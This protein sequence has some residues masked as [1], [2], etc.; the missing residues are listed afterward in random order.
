[1][2]PCRSIVVCL[3][4][5]GGCSL[6]AVKATERVLA[7]GGTAAYRIVISKDADVSTKAVGEDFAGILAEIT[8]A[9]FPIVTDDTEPAEQ[10][11]IVGA[12]NT[13]LAKL[14][15]A[16]M[17]KGFSQG[18]YEI[19]TAGGKLVI[20]GGPLRGTINGMYGFLQDHLD[21]RWFTPG[22]MKVPKQE[23]LEIG[24]I[25]DRQ[26]PDFVWRSTNPCLHWDAA[27][28]ARNR[29]NEC[30]AYGG[31][32]SMNMLMSDPRVATIGNYSSGHQFSYIPAELYDTHPE[33]YAEI[34][35]KRVRHENSN[36]RAYCLTNDGFVEYMA[37]ML[38]RSLRGSKGPRFVGLGHADNANFCRCADCKKSYDRVGLAGTYMEF[39]NKVAEIVTKEYPEAIITTLAYGITFAPT[40]VNM[41]PNMRPIWCPISCCHAHAF[42]EC[43]A[44]RDR[45]FLDQLARWQKNTSQLGIWY[46][47]HQSDTLMPH[48]K[49]HASAGDFKTFRRMGVNSIF[50][51]DNCGATTRNNAAFDGDKPLPAYG[52]AERN[53]YFTVPFGLQHLRSYL[54]CRMLWNADFD[55]QEGI[56]DF[57]DGYY[58]PAGKEL[59][60]FALMV[61]S[62]DSYEKTLGSTFRTYSGVHQSGSVSPKLTPASIERI[63]ALLEAAMANAGADNT[64]RRRAEMARASADLAILCFTPADSALRESAFDRFFSLMEE[65]GLKKIHRT[66]VSYQS[67]TVA[68]LKEIMSRPD[69]IAIPGEEALGANFLGNSSFES[70]IDGDGIP[71]GWRAD[72]D[73]LPEEY[74][75]DPGGIA[76]DD[77]R[78][79][80]GARCVRLTKTPARNAIVSLRQRFDAK[81]GEWYR[82]TVRYQADVKT[83]G[84]HIIFTAFDKDGKWLRHQ[85]GQ[86]GVKQTGGKWAEMSVDTQCQKDTAQ[87]MIEFLF[88]D[89]KSQGVAWI[90][91]FECAKIDIGKQ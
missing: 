35:G 4:V 43:D 44:N 16:D 37:A 5:L 73:Y 33:Y 14:G 26:K 72:G 70:E 57:C 27:W 30:K 55:W 17:T 8:G 63:N 90:D 79:R 2:N 81:A 23:T 6:A 58:G 25:T 40:P 66:P 54:V 75:V 86:R 39:D 61:E 71:D 48:M 19:R 42:D 88:Y 41:H 24:D 11:I 69:K 80:T 28:T 32:V 22:C 47:H 13:R 68:E 10:E 21:C 29:L 49:M 12:E 1:M 76:I 20:A 45:E 67:T 50:V 15:L 77:S 38:K 87:L 84:V 56:R 78:F 82:A 62:V 3:L 7:G 34:D 64:F 9:Q 18:E 36:Q 60:E 65:L 52:N 51:E 74:S 89:D 91:D 85:G 59:A 31:T 83:G 46:Y 53:G